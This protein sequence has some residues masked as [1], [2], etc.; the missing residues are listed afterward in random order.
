[1]EETITTAIEST[2]SRVE[3]GDAANVPTY[4]HCRRLTFISMD[5]CD[6]C[7]NVQTPG[8]FMYYISIESKNGW[9]TC[10]NEVCK[11]K[12]RA[13]VD[14]FMRTQAYGKANHLRGKCIKVKRTAGNIESG[15]TLSTAFTEFTVDC[16]GVERVCVVDKTGEI[17]KWVNVSRLIEWN[18]D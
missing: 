15:W 14:H 18:A 17:E 5:S 9:V 8:P 1:M 16:S 6:F 12:G 3:E 10:S 13:A 4:P 11:K 7:D 2:Q